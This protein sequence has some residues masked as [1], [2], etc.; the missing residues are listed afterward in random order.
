MLKE[1]ELLLL[2]FVNSFLFHLRYNYDY[3]LF[4][5][6]IHRFCVDFVLHLN[7]KALNL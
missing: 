7:L 6:L 1:N 5:Y 2:K 4:I 3:F